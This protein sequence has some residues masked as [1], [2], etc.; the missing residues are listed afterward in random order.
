MGTP[1]YVV[2]LPKM[3]SRNL[4]TER[5]LDKLELSD[6]LLNHWPGLLKS[7]TVM[8]DKETEELSQVQGH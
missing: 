5:R 6:I 1:C 2:F 3:H 7:V 8:K 4:L